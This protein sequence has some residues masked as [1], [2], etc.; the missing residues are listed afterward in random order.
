M[1]SIPPLTPNIPRDDQ[2]SDTVLRPGTF[3]DYIGQSQI[4]KNLSILIGAAKSRGHAPEH[5]LFYGPPGLGKTTLA[6]VIA[7]EVG[8]NTSNA[9]APN[10]L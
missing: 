1:S 3:D 2:F 9:V 8:A 5:I 6:H 10:S 7:K 4:K